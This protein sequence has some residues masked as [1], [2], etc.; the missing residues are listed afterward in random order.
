MLDIPL[1]AALHVL[2]L[3]LWVERMDRAGVDPGLPPRPERTHEP[4]P[5]LLRRTF[6]PALGAA[7]RRR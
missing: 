1:A 6:G 4:R 2:V 3:R 5:G 7:F